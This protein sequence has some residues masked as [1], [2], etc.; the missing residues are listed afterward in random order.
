MASGDSVVQVLEILPT[1]T[2]SAGLTRRGAS[3]TPGEGLL[4]W[5]FDAAT[6]WYLDFLCVLR[7]Y[8]GGGL[9]FTLPWM[10][11]SATSGVTRWG[12]A[13]RRLLEGEDWDLAHTYDYNV[14]D[15]TAPATAGFPL[16]SLVTFT[17]G[18]DMDN[19]A[20][21]EL[22]IVRTRRE[23]NHAN[24][25]MSGDAQLIHLYGRET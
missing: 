9:T 12:I 18:A 21:N 3:S 2:L 1:G 17:D 25:T 6:I 4:V 22:A 8:G 11:A 14:L 19:W 15:A 7:G 23:A 13:I 10:A 5:G 16:Y 20:N 24:D